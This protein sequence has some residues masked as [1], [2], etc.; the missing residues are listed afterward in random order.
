MSQCRETHRF[1]KD[2]PLHRGQVLNSKTTNQERQGKY[3]WPKFR[4]RQ[5]YSELHAVKSGFLQQQWQ[6]DA[7]EKW[8][9]QQEIKGIKRIQFHI[10]ITEEKKAHIFQDFKMKTWK[11]FQQSR[12][13]KG[14]EER[15]KICSLKLGLSQDVKRPPGRDIGWRQRLKAQCKEEEIQS[16]VANQGSQT[17]SMKSPRHNSRKGE[18]RRQSAMWY[19]PQQWSELGKSTWFAKLWQ[20][21]QQ[22]K[23]AGNKLKDAGCSQK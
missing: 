18:K 7:Q 10:L 22:I 1:L 21:Q 20:Y 2:A 23:K 5:S 15:E 4:C 16:Q 11:D 12:S 8:E 9:V 13:Q 17:S 14:T 6:K 3:L 19:K